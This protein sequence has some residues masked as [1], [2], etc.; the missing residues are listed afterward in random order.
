MVDELLDDIIEAGE[1]DLLEEFASPLPVRVIC[2]LLG[3]PAEDW[4]RFRVWSDAMARG[5]DP[6][7]LL[8]DEIVADRDAAVV[9]FAG[10]FYELL[11]DRRK[12][13]GDDLLSRLIE[14]EDGGLGTQRGG[15]A[16]DV[17]PAPGGRTRDRRRSCSPAARLALLRHPDQMERFR[18]D[19]GVQRGSHRRDAPVRDPG[20]DDGTGHDR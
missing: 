1:V 11:A 2:D 18:T 9:Q 4:G 17:H 19:P 8:S 20:A 7:F 15:D 13:P 6:D 10:Y 5:L 12:H 3:V 16:L 14:V